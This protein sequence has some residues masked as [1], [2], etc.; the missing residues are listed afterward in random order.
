MAKYTQDE[1]MVLL[2]ES[3]LRIT[4]QY[5]Y[6]SPCGKPKLRVSR[7]VHRETK[8]KAFWQEHNEDGRWE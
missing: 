7:A 2:Q 5:S 8:E 1:L 6:Y 4:G 3:E